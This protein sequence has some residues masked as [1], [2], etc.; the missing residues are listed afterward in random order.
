MAAIVCKHSHIL[1]VQRKGVLPWKVTAENN[2]I[3]GL[4]AYSI[5]FSK[6]AQEPVSDRTTL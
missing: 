1:S 2:I 4:S 5:K 6:A 3:V